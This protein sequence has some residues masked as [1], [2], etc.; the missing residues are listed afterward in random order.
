MSHDL[1]L[2]V[3]AEGVETIDQLDYLKEKECDVIQGFYFSPPLNAEKFK[4]YLDEQ[5]AD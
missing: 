1:N 3:V 2:R 4:A 5:S